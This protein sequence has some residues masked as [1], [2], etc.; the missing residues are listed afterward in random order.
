MSTNKILFLS[1]MA[2]FL[3]TS[4]SKEWFRSHTGNMPT[5]QRVE[6]IKVGMSKTEVENIIGVPSNII[7]LDKNTWLYMSSEME[8]IAFF[9]PKEI[10][11]GI[12]VI[13]FDK[14]EQVDNIAK[15]TQKDGKDISIDKDRTQNVGT[16]QGFFEKYFGGVGQYSPIA[17]S[18]GRGGM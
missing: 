12:L 2:L 14:Y 6:N 5:Q 8:Q 18:G 16:D 9:E 4:C 7:S 15:L 10:N 1:L 11:R 17:P 13:R 3:T